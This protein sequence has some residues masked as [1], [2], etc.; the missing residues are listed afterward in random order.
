MPARN[1]SQANHSRVR[2]EVTRL[3]AYL[4]KLG[5]EVVAFGKVGHYQQTRE[6]GFDHAAHFRYHEDVAIP[7]AVEAVHVRDNAAALQLRLDGE[8]LAK[9]DAAFPPPRRKMHLAVV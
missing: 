7:K 3:P 1:G 8:D 9:L 5:Y 4:K 6:H 2:E